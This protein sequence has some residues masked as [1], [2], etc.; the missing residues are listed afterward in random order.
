[1]DRPWAL[2]FQASIS[3]PYFIVSRSNARS[4]AVEAGTRAESPSWRPPGR[5]SWPRI[6]QEGAALFLMLLDRDIPFEL[7]LGRL[8]PRGL[9]KPRSCRA[10]ASA[11]F[12]W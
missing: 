10:L 7:F 9:G 5:P 8:D 2:F 3:E 12:A 11:T 1:M 6:P 4:S